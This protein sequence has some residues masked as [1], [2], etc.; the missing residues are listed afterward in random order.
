V[1]DEQMNVELMEGILSK[2]YDVVTAMSGRG[3]LSV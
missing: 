1:D 2:E 3:T